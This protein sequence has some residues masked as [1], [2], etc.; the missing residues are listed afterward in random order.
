MT[1]VLAHEPLGWRPTMPVL[2]I[3]RYQ[4]S[5]RGHVWRQD[6]GRAAEPW[7]KLSRRALRWAL[8]AL[9]LGHLTI[10]RIAQ[11]LAAS[12]NT[13]NDAVL[14]EGRRVLIDD[15]DRFDA[16]K[17]IGVDEHVWR[18]TRRGDEYVTVVI[19]LAPIRDRTGP[20]RLLDMVSAPSKPSSSGS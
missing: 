8:E 11:A 19:D 4:C 7:A 16:V 9:V 14:T 3:R 18:H 6:T 20:S 15:P 12:W 5:G 17:V 1:Q 2:T 13:A 10:A